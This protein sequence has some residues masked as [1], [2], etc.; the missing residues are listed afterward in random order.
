VIAKYQVHRG[1][2]V[3]VAMNVVELLGQV[4]RQAPVAVAGKENPVLRPARLRRWPSTSRPG[5]ARWPGL[6]RDAA[7]RRPHALRTHPKNLL[8]ADRDRATVAR[9]H[10]RDGESDSA[11]AAIRATTPPDIAI[12]DQRQNGVIERRGRNFD[13]SL[14]RRLGMRRQNL[15]QQFPLARDHK[16]LVVQRI[17]ASLLP[18]ELRRLFLPE[19]IRRTRR[20]ATAPAGR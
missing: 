18:P 10:L 8:D 12:A 19:R 9:A 13:R 5:C 3:L 14:L 1:R 11:A 20:S 15:A 7:L 17:V 4:R 2:A 6:F 16:L